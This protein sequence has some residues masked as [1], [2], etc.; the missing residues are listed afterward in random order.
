MT[1]PKKARA[2]SSAIPVRIRAAPLPAA[3]REAIELY[4]RIG[5]SMYMRSP[6]TTEKLV[7]PWK[8]LKPGFQPLEEW[9]EM[10]GDVAEEQKSIG[11]FNTVGAILGK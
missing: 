5:Q 1:G 8:A 6:E 3:T 2:F 11:G 7:R 4:A 9:V 10:K